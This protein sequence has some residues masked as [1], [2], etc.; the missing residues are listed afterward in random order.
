MS[1]KEKRRE[2]GDDKRQ[3]GLGGS[4]GK[5][6]RGGLVISKQELRGFAEDGSGKKRGGGGGKRGK[7]KK[8]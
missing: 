8:R 1:L 3:R 6:V 5:M 4:V 2:D 7:G